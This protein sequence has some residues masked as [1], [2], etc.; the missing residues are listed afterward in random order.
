MMSSV[1]PSLKY[2]CSGSPLMFT[3]GRTQIEARCPAFGGV[4]ACQGGLWLAPFARLRIKA[5]TPG[6]RCQPEIDRLK[7]TEASGG[8]SVPIRTA[9]GRGPPRLRPA[10]RG[11]STPASNDDHRIGFL[12]SDRFRRRSAT[13]PRSGDPTTPGAG[14][15]HSP[16]AWLPHLR[17]RSSERLWPIRPPAD[18]R[19]AAKFAFTS[20]VSRI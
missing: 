14:R 18:D 7:L 13:R 5:S 11:I 6:G 1:M 16:V 12:S 4:C 15:M 20:V 19:Y 2:S 17:A 3:N 10:P 8:L 9:A